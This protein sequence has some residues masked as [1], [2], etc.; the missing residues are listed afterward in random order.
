V[1]NDAFV[2]VIRTRLRPPTEAIMTNKLYITNLASNV[3]EEQL[4]A[5]FAACGGVCDVE[6]RRA[7]SSIQAFVTMTSPTYASRA[8]ALDG[9][10][11]A[12][13][14]L[15]VSDARGGGHGRA[16]DD[17]KTS[18]A[19]IQQQFRGRDNMTYELTCAG[20]PLTLRVFLLDAVGGVSAED[21]RVE[22]R[23]TDAPEAFV[24]SGSGTT[25]REAL[26]IALRGLNSNSTSTAS[27]PTRVVDADAVIA[28]MR[29]VRAV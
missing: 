27:S 8:R 5:H 15:H 25:R 23:A 12:G 16:K 22:A 2:L 18:L 14:T 10:I 21:W 28:A 26:T 24:A 11:L 3:T 7:A 20:A 19:K 9:S 6:I 29:A 17:D 13:Q 1:I 4:R